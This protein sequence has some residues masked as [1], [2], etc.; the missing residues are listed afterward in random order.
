M[1]PNSSVTPITAMI[2]VMRSL[3]NMVLMIFMI[4]RPWE[5]CRWN[6]HNLSQ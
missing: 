6:L 1:D 4:S 5:W 3:Q 2:A